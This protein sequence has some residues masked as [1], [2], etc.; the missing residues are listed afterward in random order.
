MNARTPQVAF[1]GG[2]IDPLLTQRQDYQRWQSGMAE[3]RGFMPLRQGAFTRAPGTIYRGTSRNNAKA[4]RI[5]FQFSRRD[6]LSLEFTNQKMRVWRYG[7]LIEASPGVPY[8]LDVPFLEADLASLDYV[9]DNDRVFIA[10]GKRPIQ[11]IQRFALNSWTISD[12]EF[13]NGPFEPQNIDTAKTIQASASTGTI[14]LTAGAAMFSASDVGRIMLLRPFDF[15]TVPIWSAGIQPTQTFMRNDGNIYEVID[16]L[17]TGVNPPVHTFGTQITDAGSNSEFR[18]VSTEQGIVKITSFTSATQVQAE[19]IQT[20]PKP[21]VD[22]PSHRWSFGS[23]SDETGYPRRIAKHKQRLYAANTTA[24]PRTI[25]ASAIGL[26]FDFEPRDEADASFAYDI[27]GDKSRNEILWLMGAKRGLYIGGEGEIYRGF[28]NVAGQA[29]SAETFDTELVDPDGAAD[30]RP[31]K[32]YGFPIYVSADRTQLLEARFSFEQDSERPIELSLPSRHLGAAYFNRL[33][34]QARPDRQGWLVN[35]QGD[36]LSVIYDPSEDV[37]GWAPQPYAGGF[38]EDLDITVS[39]DGAFDIVTFVV[40]REING[41]TVRYMEEVAVNFLPFLGATG[42][43]NFNHAIAGSVF[44]PGAQTATFNVPHLEGETVYA[45][46]DKGHMGPYTV[47]A[48]GQVTLDDFV[49]SAIIGMAD[50][51][52]SALTLPLRA[53]APDGDARG[54]PMRGLSGVG[55]G[56]YNVAGGTI[57]AI[58]RTNGVMERVEEPSELIDPSTIDFPKDLKTGLVSRDVPTG[59]ADEVQLELKPLGIAP[60]TITALNPPITEVGA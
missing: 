12:A 40:R 23:W 41:Q 39:A 54:R 31:Q 50:A 6:T 34:W 20:V 56:F 32:P 5:P 58:T 44:K 27:S 28:S 48:N 55:I 10:D 19:V 51:S 42:P 26:F 38:I 22:D 35:D 3:C 18:F 29:I 14:T 47:P 46:T 25:W 49:S 13:V 36:G 1:S 45:W 43:E 52:H 53:P 30:V 59:Y 21:I 8:E 15:S 24:A 17:N 33:E 11:L 7:Q 37:L 16:G 2:E 57:Q 9:Q 4:R 60:M